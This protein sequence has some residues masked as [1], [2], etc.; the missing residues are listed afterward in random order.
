LPQEVFVQTLIMPNITILGSTGSIGVNTLE[1]LKL[2]QKHFTVFALTAQK[3][4][5]LIFKQCLE[6]RP[7]YAVLQNISAAEQLSLKLKQAGLETEALAEEQ[8]LVD[9]ASHPETDYVMAA[10]VGAAGLLPTIAAARSG[11][12]ILLANKESLVMAGSLLMAEVEENDAVLLPVDS[13]HSAIFQCL[14]ANFKIGCSP[15]GIEQI[16][17]T[18]S[19]GA[20]RDWPED[21][22]HVVTPEQACCHPNW[23]MG[24][25]ITVDCAT[26]MNKGLEVIEASWLFGLQPEQIHTVLHPQS[27]IHSW[28]EYVD[29]SILA[30]MG[31]PDMRTPIAYALSWPERMQAGGKRLN[32]LAVQQLEFRPLSHTRYPCL[33]LAYAALKSGGTAP[34]I[35]NAAN[36]VAVQAFLNRQV[37][38]TDIV[39]IVE[40][41]LEMVEI[42]A[43]NILE[44]VLSA[45][46]IARDY[47]SELIEKIHKKVEV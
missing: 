36:E 46:K 39:K 21:Q 32:L 22:L 42:S 11:K 33:P 18:A 44:T 13:E 24:A 45:D 15:C 35:L 9:M 25:K 1:I 19:G 3:N 38:F 16:V 2:H 23:S 12:R 27:V 6:H 7:R 41:T 47:S 14:P 29:G 28:V 20:F 10:I 17:L 8:A 34:T 4:V 5:E 40:K 26:M 31:S 43:A 37:L 30:Q